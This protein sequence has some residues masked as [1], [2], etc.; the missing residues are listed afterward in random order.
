ML[1]IF[2]FVHY[3]FYFEYKIFDLVIQH[4]SLST[5]KNREENNAALYLLL[6]SVAWARLQPLGGFFMKIQEIR[7]LVLKSI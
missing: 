1:S 3:H 6:K 5:K 2:E 7:F 4:A